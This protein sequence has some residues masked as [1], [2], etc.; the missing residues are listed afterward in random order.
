MYREWEKRSNMRTDYESSRKKREI[1]YPE[2]QKLFMKEEFGID[3]GAFSLQVNF[4]FWLL[5]TILLL[6]TKADFFI[7]KMEQKD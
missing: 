6:I 4:F 3:A 2:K 7:T 1:S 5:E